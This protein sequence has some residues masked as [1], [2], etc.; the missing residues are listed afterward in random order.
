MKINIR[1]YTRQFYRGNY[2]RLLIALIGAFVNTAACLLIS[3]LIQQ[4][5]DLCT[6][7]DTGF[8]LLQL[9][10]LSLGALGFLAAEYLLAFFSK[11]R[12]VAKAMSQYKEFIFE[13]LCRK[14]ISAFSGENSS[15][16]ISALSNDAASIETGY[17]ANIFVLVN[18]SLM[19]VGALGLM[20]WY[21]PLLTL[22]SLGLTLLPLIASVCTGNLVAKAEAQVSDRNE[23]YISALKD[24]LMGF[25]VIK[26]FRAE[27]QMR[28]IFAEKVRQV[29]QAKCL[30]NKMTL[31]VDLLG[32]A[33]GSIVQLG[34]ML[35]G[36][37]MALSGAALT[38]G[39]VLVFVQLL[40]FVISPIA[41]IPKA[42]AE[43]KAARALIQ[44]IATA[45]E[46]NVREDGSQE[47]QTME[48]GITLENLSFGY[49][50]EKPVLQNVDFTF[51][52]GKRYALV[53]ASG[54]GK[55][56]L[57]N[58]LLAS[59]PQY[60]GA[61]RYDETELRQLK[62]EN[63]YE[64]ACQIQQNV[65]IFNA[66]IRDNI[67]MF[68]DF[69]KEAVD[70]AIRLSGLDA[71]IDEKSED[72]LCGE[73]G[74]GLS[75]GERQRVSIARALLKNAQ[76]LLVDEATASLDAQTAFQVTNAILDLENI[77]RIL[78]TH[79]LEEALLQRFDC[80][81]AIKNGRIQE[82]GTFEELMAQK[83]Y[84]Y[85]LFNVSQ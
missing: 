3:W 4:I 30:R 42:L 38:A 73:N 75:G 10:L 18:Q 79:S 40:N 54:S 85:S 27:T 52:A 50:P 53:G 46:E 25:S 81:L 9:F 21:N 15:L 59:Y 33:S 12:F 2:W 71:L 55:S 48:Q 17:L 32:T 34:V 39:S 65:F 58:L 37:W 19:F 76:V 13:R 16:Y 41:L 72:Y 66:S 8:S 63:L 11:P 22:I 7:I 47:K 70:R 29:A 24:S 61:I 36:A 74:S 44:K 28:R 67:T 20:F 80:I 6:G 43:R 84:F 64:L 35:I 14:G 78:V 62:S 1:P 31:L 69:P 5:I 56:T 83:G 68:S 23:T 45:L 82:A 57:L 51:Q 26:T 49:E 77:T 60:S